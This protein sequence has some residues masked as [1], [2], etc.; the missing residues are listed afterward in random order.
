MAN[1]NFTVTF[2]AQPSFYQKTDAG[3]HRAIIMETIEASSETLLEMIKEEAPVR[4]GR[5]RDGHYIET[6]GDWANIK[7][8][9]YYWK[10]V[11]A[12]GNDYINR[13]LL[14]FINSQTIQTNYTEL[15]LSQ[16]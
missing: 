15:I 5:L 10:Y 7:N 6:R 16:I 4:T 9:A 1:N 12:L 11:I 13:G 8:E 2:E 3:L 14:E